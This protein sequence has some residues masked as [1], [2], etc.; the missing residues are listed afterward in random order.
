[1]LAHSRI[2]YPSSWRTWANGAGNQDISPG[3]SQFVSPW[4]KA[5]LRIRRTRVTK[6]SGPWFVFTVRTLQDSVCGRY[7][8][9][10]SVVSLQVSRRSTSRPQGEARSS[11]GTQEGIHEAL[12]AR[13]YVYFLQFY[14]LYNGY[15]QSWYYW[16]IVSKFTFL[17]KRLEWNLHFISGVCSQLSSER[18]HWSSLPPSLLTRWVH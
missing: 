6:H 12:K 18:L 13:F 14:F 9:V 16:E 1:M 7:S 15:Q 2:P 8:A 11:D 10:G 17:C 4:C 3:S 5:S